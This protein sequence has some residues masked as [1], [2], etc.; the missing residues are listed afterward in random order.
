ML[1]A[2]VLMALGQISKEK[3]SQIDRRHIYENVYRCN[4]IH[5]Y[6]W[7][8]FADVLSW[9]SKRTTQGLRMWVEGK[10]IRDP[11]HM[12]SPLENKHE[13]LPPPSE[14]APLQVILF[15]VKR[16]GSEIAMP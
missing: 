5:V 3:A 15:V 14:P 7:G 1:S 9:L 12:I 8:C 13:R 6:I 10:E 2:L 16:R 11:N 4:G